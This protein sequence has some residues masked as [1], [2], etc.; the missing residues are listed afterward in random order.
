MSIHENFLPQREL[1]VA[2][3][4]TPDALRTYKNETSSLKVTVICI[5]T[6]L[7]ST[8]K[9][10][11]IG[12]LVGAL[13]GIPGGT[14]GMVDG[15]QKWSLWGGAAGFAYGGYLAYKD[16]DV[17]IT[18]SSFFS[19]WKAQAIK[20]E[21]FN[22]FN[23]F[24][25]QQTAFSPLVDPIEANLLICPVICPNGHRYN[26]AWIEQWNDSQWSKINA[27]VAANASPETIQTLKDQ[28]C[29]KRGKPY[30]RDQ[31]KYDFKAAKDIV[32]AID[33]ILETNRERG[34][35]AESIIEGLQNIAKD[36]RAQKNSIT[37]QRLETLTSDARNRNI[38]KE[39][40]LHFAG[41][42]YDDS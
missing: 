40:F 10:S 26:R 16:I 19:D 17:L 12:G 39:Q 34:E 4:N 2:R 36:I 31:L 29:P 3:Y 24:I 35:I 20:N 32:N 28:V 6:I 18:K 25:R 9:Y 23:A 11:C 37:A 33:S 7:K 38:G 1:I 41:S 27:A 22:A 15:F 5:P 30:T 13:L 14:K 8:F 42:V 21:T